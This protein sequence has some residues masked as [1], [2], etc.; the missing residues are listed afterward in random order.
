MNQGTTT[1]T[2]GIHARRSHLHD[3]IY[4]SVITVFRK[5]ECRNAP[6]YEAKWRELKPLQNAADWRCK[7]NAWRHEE[8]HRSYSQQD[9]SSAQDVC[10][11]QWLRPANGTLSQ[12]VSIQVSLLCVWVCMCSCVLNIWYLFVIF[13]LF[14]LVLLFLAMWPSYQL[15]YL[16]AYW[17]GEFSV[18]VLSY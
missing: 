7:N 1:Q 9:C 10:S 18:P 12:D 13:G 2:T 14:W 11:H 6:W 16:Y 5:R 17:G 15:L 8:S 3:A 4:N